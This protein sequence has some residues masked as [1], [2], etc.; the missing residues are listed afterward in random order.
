M[1]GMLRRRL[2]PES[3]GDF[4]RF[5]AKGRKAREIKMSLRLA[6]K[7]RFCLVDVGL[8]IDLSDTKEQV[9]AINARSLAIDRITF[10]RWRKSGV[11][12]APLAWQAGRIGSLGE[13]GGADER[14][15]GVT[16]SAGR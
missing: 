1:L 16:R 13:C 12:P 14:A 9:D 4:F 7:D 3:R 2:R 10:R 5:I 11:I 15:A 8:A 6:E